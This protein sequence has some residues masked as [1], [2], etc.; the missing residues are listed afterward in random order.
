MK[1]SI[2]KLILISCSKKI[3]VSENNF[4]YIFTSERTGRLGLEFRASLFIVYL[5]YNSF[6]SGC[7]LNQSSMNPGTASFDL[8]GNLHCKYTKGLFMP[9]C[10]GTYVTSQ[11]KLVVRQKK[12]LL[13]SCCNISFFIRYELI[14]YVVL[15]VCFFF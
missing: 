13:F 3:K 7:C 11:A 5:G 8:T 9:S 14:R 4:S 2:E 15:F 10:A 6:K 1:R 12:M